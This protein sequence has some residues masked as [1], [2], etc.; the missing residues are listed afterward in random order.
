MILQLS[1]SIP[2]LSGF[3]RDTDP[4]IKIRQDVQWFRKGLSFVEIVDN[5]GKDIASD[6]I[7]NYNSSPHKTGEPMNLMMGSSSARYMLFKQRGS[8]KLFGRSLL[9][10]DKVKQIIIGKIS[11]GNGKYILESDSLQPLIFQCLEDSGYLYIGGKGMVRL[12]DSTS[13]RLRRLKK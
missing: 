6:I 4:P 5:N 1:I 11:I 2:A 7:P 9:F 12:P 8:E 13:I 10:A 3:I